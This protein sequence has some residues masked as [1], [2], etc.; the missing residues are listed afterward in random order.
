MKQV[1]YIKINNDIIDNPKDNSCNIIRNISE[2]DDNQDTSIIT[3]N[4][5]T[6]SD[7]LPCDM[8][9][10]EFISSDGSLYG[11]KYNENSKDSQD[12]QDNS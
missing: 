3:D 4:E 7:E 9:V 10:I 1:F 11:D 8:K 2:F 12:S 6:E 5:S